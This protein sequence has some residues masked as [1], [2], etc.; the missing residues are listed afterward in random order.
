M[1]N[2]IATE[3]GVWARGRKGDRRFVQNGPLFFVPRLLWILAAVITL[4]LPTSEDGISLMVILSI[5]WMVSVVEGCFGTF[6]TPSGVYFLAGG[7]FV[8][9]A[10]FYLLGV[11]STASSIDQLHGTIILA[12]SLTVLTELV[13]ALFCIKWKVEWERPE[14]PDIN[15]SD[16]RPP[17]QFMLR[18]VVLVVV[19][20]LPVII[21][22]NYELATALG[23]AGMVILSMSALSYRRRI[24]WLGDLLIVAAGFAIP[25]F[26]VSEVFKGGGRL[27]VAGLGIALMMIW[28]MIRASGAHKLVLLLAI[29]VFLIGSGFNRLDK[30]EREYGVVAE[31]NTS[32]VISSGAGLESVYDPIDKFGYILSEPN[33]PGGGTI[34][35]RYGAT[36]VNSLFMPIPRSMWETKP[37]GFGAELT[38]LITPQLVRINQSWAALFYSEW[39]ANFGYVGLAIAPVAVGWFIA[40]LDRT[41]ARLARSRLATPKDWWDTVVLVCL[42]T[43]LGDLFW[44]G[45]FTY[46]TRGGM[47]AIVAWV[48]GKISQVRLR[49]IST[50]IRAVMVTAR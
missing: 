25:V 49:S 35:P 23:L 16:F 8:G 42:V 50:N 31:A 1:P 17:V 4:L 19:S 21:A 7:I 12:F 36:F 26:W 43:S 37:K 48:V 22:L 39:Y 14:K 33:Y 46:Y 28:N 5:S 30:I 47:A 20:R 3:A 10:G 34:G 38:E 13:A 9:V 44:A 41:H 40:R 45:T 6:L 18:G 27:T 11:D 29:P 32:D 15:T 24:R 2:A